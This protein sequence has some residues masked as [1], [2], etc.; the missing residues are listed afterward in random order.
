VRLL[1]DS[2]ILLAIALKRLDAVSPSIAGACST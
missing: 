2:H 1:L